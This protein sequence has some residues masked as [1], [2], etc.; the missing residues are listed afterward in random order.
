MVARA[1][2]PSDQEA[3]AGGFSVSS[4]PFWSTELVYK[5]TGVVTQKNPKQTNKKDFFFSSSR[6]PK[7]LPQ[8]PSA[9]G[10]L[11]LQP[12][13]QKITAACASIQL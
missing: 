2:N 13:G 3:E 1:F 10:L 6:Q 12:H 9:K 4:R 11:G 5:T 8:L 7:F